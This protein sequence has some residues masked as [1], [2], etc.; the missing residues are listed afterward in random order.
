MG[1][2]R[3][4]G[5]ARGSQPFGRDSAKAIGRLKACEGCI[6]RARR[7]AC[8]T[9]IHRKAQTRSRYFRSTATSARSRRSA[10]CC[11]SPIG[12]RSNCCPRCQLSGPPVASQGCE[13]AAGSRSGL[14]GGAGGLGGG[15][16]RRGGG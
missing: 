9:C 8:S 12:A 10:K 5:V 14:S 11:F 7:S 3:V 6:R 2:G 4:V 13:L 16:G 1:E 15:G